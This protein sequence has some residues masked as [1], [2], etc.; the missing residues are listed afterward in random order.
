MDFKNHTMQ[1]KEAEM[2]SVV[3]L[4]KGVM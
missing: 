4:G 3:F 2:A 1:C